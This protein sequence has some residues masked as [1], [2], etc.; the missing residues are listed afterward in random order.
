[1]IEIESD[2][3]TFGTSVKVNG[4]E[5]L[6]SSISF[7]IKSDKDIIANMAVVL[8]EGDKISLKDETPEHLEFAN[9][10]VKAEMRRK[11]EK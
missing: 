1:M 2:G 11:E 9:K 3:T 10:I 5:I 7:E 6:V 4:K 8:V